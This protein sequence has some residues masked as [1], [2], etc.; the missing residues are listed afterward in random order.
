M[1]YV[2]W[3]DIRSIEVNPISGK[4][5]HRVRMSTQAT[6]WTWLGDVANVEIPLTQQQAHELARRVQAWRLAALEAAFFAQ[7]CDMGRDYKSP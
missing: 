4:A 5:F 7:L 6:P 3:T 2:P 1:V